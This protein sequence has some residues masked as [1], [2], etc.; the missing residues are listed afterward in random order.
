MNKLKAQQD[1]NEIN[2]RINELAQ[3]YDSL[4]SAK[5]DGP[6]LQMKSVSYACGLSGSKDNTSSGSAGD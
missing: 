2:Q 4:L 3:E 1:E 5:S 6:R